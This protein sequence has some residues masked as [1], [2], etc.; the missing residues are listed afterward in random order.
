MAVVSQKLV[1]VGVNRVGVTTGSGGER[2]GSGGVS[3]IIHHH[4]HNPAEST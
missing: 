4:G 2:G 3:V 1:R